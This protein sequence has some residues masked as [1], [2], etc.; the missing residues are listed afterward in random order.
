[1]TVV[2]L[3]DKTW[4]RD[5]RQNQ[6]WSRHWDQNWGCG[7]D[8]G[9]YWGWGWDWGYDWSCLAVLWTV[10]RKPKQPESAVWFEVES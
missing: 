6:N 3:G 7:W 2:T 5:R 9:W 1:M 10:P 4:P 8:W